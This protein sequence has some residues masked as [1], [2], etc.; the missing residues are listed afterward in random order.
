MGLTSLRSSRRPAHLA[1]VP[2]S[3]DEREKRNFWLILNLSFSFVELEHA[4]KPTSSRMLGRNMALL[5]K[6]GTW[7]TLWRECC[8]QLFGSVHL[9][10]C[11]LTVFPDYSYECVGASVKQA[12]S[13]EP[14][15]H[16][17][18]PLKRRRACEQQDHCFF[19]IKA[20]PSGAAGA[21]FLFPDQGP[22][23]LN[24]ARVPRSTIPITGIRSNSARRIARPFL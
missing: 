9:S 22:L 7:C 12:S 20:E 2:C 5:A 10:F 16:G 11:C 24:W 15:S 17:N 4:S 21:Q 1:G 8:I 14:D 18:R 19:S 13:A 6:A 3:M 23:R